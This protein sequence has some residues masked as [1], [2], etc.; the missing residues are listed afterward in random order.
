MSALD[1]KNEIE[2]TISKVWGEARENTLVYLKN[3]LPRGI[4]RTFSNGEPRFSGTL[5]NYTDGISGASL[6]GEK[7]YATGALRDSYMCVYDSGYDFL[8]KGG[9]KFMHFAPVG[10]PAHYAYYYA[11]GRRN[12]PTYHGFDFIKATIEDIEK[13]ASGW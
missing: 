3:N 11:N 9:V 2:L 4:G 6:A 8:G 13:N 10:D 5:G 1:F 12:S 7:L